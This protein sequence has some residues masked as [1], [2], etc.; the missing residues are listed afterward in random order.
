MAITNP[1]AIAPVR[2]TASDKRKRFIQLIPPPVNNT[3]WTLPNAKLERTKTSPHTVQLTTRSLAA[4][5]L[6]AIYRHPEKRLYTAGLTTVSDPDPCHGFHGPPVAS[7]GRPPR[8]EP[9][10]HAGPSRRAGLLRLGSESAAGSMSSRDPCGADSQT[11]SSYQRPPESLTGSGRAMPLCWASARLRWV[12]VCSEI[13]NQAKGDFAR[14]ATFTLD[15][16]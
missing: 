14:D 6:T 9:S 2:T 7:L 12:W 5:G 8:L 16:S 3:S 11:C 1:T 13:A 4:I 15:R 10:R